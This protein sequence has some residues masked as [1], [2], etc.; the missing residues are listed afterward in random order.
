[1]AQSLKEL[2]DFNQFQA[3]KE[4]QDILYKFQMTQ[5][6]FEEPNEPADRNEE[7]NEFSKS[8]WK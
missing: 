1:M 5:F 8:D 4:I 2:T 3:R 7:E 6:S